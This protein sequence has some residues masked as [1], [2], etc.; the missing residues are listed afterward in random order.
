M[1]AKTHSKPK[2]L[3]GPQRALRRAAVFVSEGGEFRLAVALFP[4]PVRQTHWIQILVAEAEKEYVHLTVCTLQQEGDPRVFDVLNAHLRDVPSHPAHTRAVI[5]T[6]ISSHLPDASFSRLDASPRPRIAGELNLDRELFE[7]HC[8]CPVILALT[9]TAHSQLLRHAPDLMHWCSQTF[10]FSEPQPP[11]EI[12]S[13]RGE[14]ELQSARPGEVYSNLTELHRAERVFREGLTSAIAAHGADSPRTL[15]VRSNL[16]N[17]LHQMG[18]T[19][20]AL[21]LARENMAIVE[22]T[23]ALQEI[24][25]SNQLARFAYF[26]EELGQHAEAEPL[27]RRAL[28]I[29]EASFGKDHPN[30]A[31]ALNNLAKLLQA[32][33]RLAEAEPLMRRALAIDEASFGKDH[34]KV[35]L[36][37]NNL[38]QLLRARNRLEEAEPLM[39][40]G[41]A[42]EENSKGKHHPH[43][44]IHLSNLAG[45]L[46]ATNRLAEAEQMMRRA[47]AIHEA[48]FGE[49][50]PN[51]AIDLNNLAKLLQATNRLA[52]AEPLMRRALAIDEASFGNDHPRVARRLNNLAKLLVAMNRLTEAEPLMARALLISNASPG[53][54]IQTV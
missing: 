31:M 45:L 14:F 44:A 30:V 11:G 29:G 19:G 47:S 15:D 22:K 13:A 28:A 43:V 37:L 39:R 7:R 18:C 34:P 6:G 17:V 2:P 53:A 40:R 33:N 46:Q 5:V 20:D 50:H 9:V 54:R 38:A 21:A 12:I 41:L 32:T 49:D 51:V 48:C 52:E 8:P 42:I 24:E 16:A 23:S 27:M 1:A 35:A 4:H 3:S 10:D 25:V 26:L 36:R